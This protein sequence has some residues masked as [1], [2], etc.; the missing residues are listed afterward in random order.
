MPRF[1]VA[2]HGRG[3]PSSRLEAKQLKLHST[4]N[5]I[6]PISLLSISSSYPVLYCMSWLS[7]QEGSAQLDS[8]GTVGQANE[9]ASKDVRSDHELF[10]LQPSTS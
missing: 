5:S 7:K 3:A 8:N 1:Y 2:L 9:D 10:A 4:M 6:L